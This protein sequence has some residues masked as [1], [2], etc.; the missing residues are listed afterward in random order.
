MAIVELK[1][2]DNFDGIVLIKKFE[3]KVARNGKDYIDATFADISGEISAKLW[4]TGIT[5]GEDLASGKF[6]HIRGN[7]ESYNSQL[8]IRLSTITQAF[9]TDAEMRALVPSAPYPPEKMYDKLLSMLNEIKNEDIRNIA[10]AIFT[11]RKEE[12]L[13][14]P[15]AK[16]FHHAVKGGLLYHTY[17]MLRSALPLLEIYD[18]LNRDLIYAG[19]ILHDLGKIEEMCSDE[20][21]IVNEYSL[22][23]N[24]LG[25]IITMICKIDEKGREFKADAEVIVLLKHMILAHHMYPE[26]GSPK[27]PMFAEAEML[28]HLDVL[29]ARM[30]QMHSITSPMK[31]GEFAERVWALDGRTVYK[32]GL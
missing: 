4:D 7:V 14:F 23:G 19:V 16:K 12:L 6:A 10:I 30:N 5:R 24:L 3:T 13:Y 32:H 20:H 26:F 15:A 22:E 31:S 21:G 8:Q 29:D 28:H 9:P 25:H 27:M 2:N 11:E 17:S 18:F 1:A